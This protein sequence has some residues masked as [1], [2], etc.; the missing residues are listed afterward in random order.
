M[1]PGAGNLMVPVGSGGWGWNKQVVTAG[2][3]LT[4]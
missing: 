4:W 2:A 1:G 3:S